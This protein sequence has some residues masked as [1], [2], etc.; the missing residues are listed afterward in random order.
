M[1]FKFG[2]DVEESRNVPKFRRNA[3]FKINSNLIEHNP[4]NSLNLGGVKIKSKALLEKLRI[5]KK[6]NHLQQPPRKSKSEFGKKS[7]NSRN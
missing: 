5:E 7:R 4:E 1:K 3:I 6:K 2:T